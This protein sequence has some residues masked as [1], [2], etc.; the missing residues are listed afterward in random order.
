MIWANDEN[1]NKFHKICQ[2]M[3]LP[4][5]VTPSPSQPDVHAQVNDPSVSVH[6]AWG[7]QLL[8]KGF[9]GGKSD[10]HILPILF[11]NIIDFF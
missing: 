3:N 10:T 1:K 5:Q 8:S 4:V 6:V 11:D 7:S 9:G 2:Y